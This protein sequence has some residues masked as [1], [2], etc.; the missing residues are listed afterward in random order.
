MVGQM[1][2][3]ADGFDYIG[4]CVAR[5]ADCK[6]CMNAVES[7]RNAS[8]GEPCCKIRNKPTVSKRLGRDVTIKVIETCKPGSPE[9][10]DIPEAGFST[11]ICEK[12]G[13]LQITK[14]KHT[15]SKYCRDCAKEAM[16]EASREHK[17]RKRAQA[18]ALGLSFREYDKRRIG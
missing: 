16:A 1:K 3:Y 7:L 12:C 11:Y 13:E 10:A 5:G 2:I 18:K 6:G 8:T 15:K 4:M 14:A 9:E 17:R